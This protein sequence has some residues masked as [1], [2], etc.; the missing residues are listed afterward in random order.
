M[1]R[2]LFNILST[3]T[4]RPQSEAKRLEISF[5]TKVEKGNW[6]RF[7][8]FLVAW[9]DLWPLSAWTKAK[10][11][12]YLAFKIPD[13]TDKSMFSAIKQLCKLFPK[14]NRSS[15]YLW[16]GFEQDLIWYQSST[17]KMVSLQN[18]LWSSR[19]W[20]P[21]NCCTHSCNLSSLKMLEQGARWC[22][23]DQ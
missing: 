17:T 9:T 14:G 4:V 21:V 2:W 5:D 11:R 6:E 22:G 16:W 7:K 15:S 18:C 23:N 10:T 12:F 3:E 19:G 8:I 13:R 1:P 20:V